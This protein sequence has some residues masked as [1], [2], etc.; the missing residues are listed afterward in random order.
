MRRAKFGFLILALLVLVL[1]SYVG[2]V[3]MRGGAFGFGQSA[4]GTDYILD[5][6]CNYCWRSTQ[7]RSNDKHGLGEARGEVQPRVDGGGE[8]T[9][10]GGQHQQRQHV[11]LDVVVG[12]RSGD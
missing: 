8:E 9:D 11:G 7:Q 10:D 1:A 4:K 12:D 2:N 5:V 6:T 3:L